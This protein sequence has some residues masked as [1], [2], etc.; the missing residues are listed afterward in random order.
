[1]QRRADEEIGRR[2]QARHI[3]APAEEADPADD[4]Q[5]GRE[6]LEA[7]PQRAV[8]GDPQG[9]L[10]GCGESLE[11]QVEPLVWV[12]PANGQRQ[13]RPL[14]RRDVARRGRRVGNKIRQVGD[15]FARPAFGNRIIDNGAGV[16]YQMVAAAIIFQIVITAEA[17][18]MYKVAARAQPRG[19]AHPGQNDVGAP[20]GDLAP[21]GA[22]GREVEDAAEGEFADPD[23]GGAK[24]LRPATLSC[25]INL[26]TGPR[27]VPARSSAKASWGM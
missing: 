5:P 24:R 6:A 22:A 19:A 11:Q 7:R 18:D 4:P 14:P 2:Q 26:S 13:W 10:P 21:E 9:D 1:M 27:S 23:P 15:P 20:S 16:S 17:G 3:L 12:K 25:P 8:P